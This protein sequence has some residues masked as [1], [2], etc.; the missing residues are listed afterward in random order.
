ME[1]RQMR[2]ILKGET[3]TT[4]ETMVVICLSLYLPPE[5]SFYIIEKPNITFKFNDDSHKGYRFVLNPHVGKSLD[6]TRGFLKKH[7]V[8]L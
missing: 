8:Y 5:I 3:N 4:I 2:R 6:E 7:D 1:E